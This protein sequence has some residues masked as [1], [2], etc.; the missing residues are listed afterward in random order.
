M[1]EG[2]NQLTKHLLVIYFDR[3]PMCL[4]RPRLD[5]T[6]M[7]ASTYTLY[8]PQRWSIFQSDGMVNV[9]FQATIE[10]NGFSMVLTTLDHH[11]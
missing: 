4:N 3:K 1:Q 11:H 6:I 10:V 7:Q 9:F 8:R 5:L 2:T